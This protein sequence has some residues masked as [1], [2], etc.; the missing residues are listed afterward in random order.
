M[1]IKNFIGKYLEQDKITKVE[2]LEGK[3]TKGKEVIKLTFEG[4]K[5]KIITQEVAV[6][7]VSDEPKDA[8][9]MREDL[10]KVMVAELLV[11]LL[12]RRIKVDDID[13]LFLKLNESI[14]LTLKL[15]ND[16]LWGKTSNEKT[17]E[18]VNK[19]LIDKK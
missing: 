5:E 4:D 19:I 3:T 1:N 10:M 2:L 14:N 11:V 15:A 12:E 16:K 13:Y 9:T 17:L 8:T 7:Q 6:I 18:D